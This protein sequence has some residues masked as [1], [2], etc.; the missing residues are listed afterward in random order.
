MCQSY[1]LCAYIVTGQQRK[2]KRIAIDRATD[3]STQNTDYE[4]QDS[5]DPDWDEDDSDEEGK[6]LYITPLSFECPVMY[7]GE[8][9]RGKL[10]FSYSRY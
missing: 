3:S 2:I 8:I 5:D 9:L 1:G 4:E 6:V 10:F 7:F